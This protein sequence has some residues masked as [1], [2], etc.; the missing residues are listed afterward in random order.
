MNKLDIKTGDVITDGLYVKRPEDIILRDYCLNKSPTFLLAPPR[1]GKSSMIAQIVKSLKNASD[2]LTVDVAIFSQEIIITHLESKLISEEDS[3]IRFYEEVFVDNIFGRIESLSLG[4]KKASIE[5]EYSKIVK[6]KKKRP[7]T[8]FENF[9]IDT[10]NPL[11]EKL[12]KNLVIFIDEIGSLVRLPFRDSLFLFSRAVNQS[13]KGRINFVFTGI[14]STDNLLKNKSSQSLNSFK[15]VKIDFFT[16][17]QMNQ[18]QDQIKNINDTTLDIIWNWTKGYPLF[19]QIFIKEGYIT[20]NAH[21]RTQPL[22]PLFDEE[23]IKEITKRIR[24]ENERVF[25]LCEDML[26]DDSLLSS[27]G[28]S[29]REIL[30]ELLAIIDRKL[31]WFNKSGEK[32]V[33]GR[34]SKICGKNTMMNSNAMLSGKFLTVNQ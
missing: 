16:R 4:I 5:K 26:T 22:K 12:D 6:K 29:K 24:R 1:L 7:S 30:S 11:L 34:I 3:E 25:G 33:F 8:Y 15:F 23:E 10:L 19:T 21:T 2:Y 9:F 20:L 32:T 17:D 13:T 18:Y 31:T 28:I 27:L 14:A